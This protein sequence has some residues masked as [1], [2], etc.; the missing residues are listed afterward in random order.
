MIKDLAS[1]ETSAKTSNVE[2]VIARA[3]KL[4][5]KVELEDGEGACVHATLHNATTQLCGGMLF[6]SFSFFISSFPFSSL[7]SITLWFLLL[8]LLSS[9]RSILGTR[10]RLPVQ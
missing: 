6:Y 8:L 4:L 1:S 9:G 2:D 5:E 7:F 10:N 3:D